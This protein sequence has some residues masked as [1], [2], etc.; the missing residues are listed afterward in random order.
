MKIG[1][2]WIMICTA[3][4]RTHAQTQEMEQ[5]RLDLEKLAQFKLM[6]T[7][8]K[9]GYQTMLSGYSAL[10]D[11]GKTNFNLHKG[12][13]DGLLAVNP[14]VARQ[15]AVQRIY[16]H[17]NRIISDS[18]SWITRLRNTQVFKA[19]EIAEV[20]AD[21]SNLILLL[22]AD[23][24]LLEKVLTPGTYRMSDAERSEII[25]TIEVSVQKHTQKF[26]ELQ[27]QY[28]RQLSLRL[29]SKKDAQD[30]RRLG[31]Q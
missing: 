13:L 24:D 27:E 9:S 1:L 18:K 28:N 12:F 15:P 7:E 11:I 19:S 16:A 8:M 21:Y 2:V 4:V 26:S 31:K 29:Q 23:R 30:I 20:V 10:R 5:L 22:E 14:S 17:Q 25:S 3:Y 6:L